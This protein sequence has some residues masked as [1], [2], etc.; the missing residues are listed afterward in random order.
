M[1][2]SH[3][4]VSRSNNVS[5]FRS[6]SPVLIFRRTVGVCVCVTNRSC[7]GGVL[8][9]VNFK[10][11]NWMSPTNPRSGSS[12]LS[13]RGTRQVLLCQTDLA[14]QIWPCLPSQ[15]VALLRCRQVDGCG[16][17]TW[18]G[19]VVWFCVPSR[20]SRLDTSRTRLFETAQWKHRAAV[21]ARSPWTRLFPVSPFRKGNLALRRF[22]AFSQR[23]PRPPLT[24]SST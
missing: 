3:L 24:W 6:S 1:S 22:I 10:T 16:F 7:S 2:R 5:T 21:S 4:R 14:A 23:V 19:T 15:P 20:F 9:N 13:Y 18:S 12:N 8:K 17:L 11:A